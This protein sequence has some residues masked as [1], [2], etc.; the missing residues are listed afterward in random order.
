MDRVKQKRP[1]LVVVNLQWTPKDESAT[2][3]I[4][5]KISSFQL[6]YKE[7]INVCL[8]SNKIGVIQITRW[9]LN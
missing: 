5:G 9:I 2:I 7:A 1:K 6:Y 3:K 4:N 8:F